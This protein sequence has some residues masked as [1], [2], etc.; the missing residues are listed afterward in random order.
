M[1]NNQFLMRADEH[2][3][4]ANSQLSETTTQGEVSASLMYAA[5]RFNAWM[6]STSFESAETMKE[7]KEKIIE[8]FIQEYKIALSENINNHIENYDFSKNDV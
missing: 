2:I 3:K 8:Y 1:N 4:L 5:A 6:A 7:E